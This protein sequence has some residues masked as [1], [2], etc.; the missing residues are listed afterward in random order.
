MGKRNGNKMNAE[1]SENGNISYSQIAC[2]TIRII[3]AHA[4]KKDE[5]QHLSL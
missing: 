4:I 2:V 3:G 1:I 5:L